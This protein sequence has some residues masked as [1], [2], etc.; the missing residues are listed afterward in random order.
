[1]GGASFKYEVTNDTIQCKEAEF[2]WPLYCDMKKLTIQ[3]LSYEYRWLNI[4]L[5]VGVMG[6]LLPLY[7]AMRLR[8][9]Y[10][11]G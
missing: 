11:S 6:G 4:L 3:K 9:P 1:M 5:E 7:T 10:C 8:Q 2:V